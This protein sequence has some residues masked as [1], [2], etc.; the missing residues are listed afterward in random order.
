MTMSSVILGIHGLANKPEETTLR[1]WWH[2]AL[3]EGLKRNEGRSSDQPV[4]FDLTY[5]ANLRYD[6]PDTAPEP[7][8]KAPGTG[9]LPR[10]RDGWLDR[11]VAEVGD[12]G[13][14]AIDW[15]KRHFEV[16]SVAQAALG[17]G[18][19]DLAAYYKER[20]VR[21]AIRERF[22]KAIQRHRGKR[23]MVIAHSMGSIIAYDVLRLLGREP[24]P[25]AIDHFVTI[26][27][28]LGLPH[29]K[30]KIYQENDR[31]RTPS[32]V[33]RWTNLADRRDPVSA[34][35]HLADD[36]GPNNQGIQVRDDLV[37]NGYSY[38]K[39]G[40]EQANHH[41]SYGYLRTPELSA[42]VRSFV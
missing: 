26:G 33:R 36:Y 25:I 21:Q 16:D 42:L 10:Y 3:V 7:Y 19:P 27:S 31:V 32:I 22:A 15:L 12:A 34:D 29:V 11:V 30:Y 5:W 37:I 18:A 2:A 39:D 1:Q 20:E 9:P 14:T 17:K 13:D 35:T 24:D 8:I 4:G 6:T 41:K 23:I 28:P 40:E 38:Q